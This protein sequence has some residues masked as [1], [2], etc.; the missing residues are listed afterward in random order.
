MKYSKKE[1][2]I[3]SPIKGAG[4]GEENMFVKETNAK[5]HLKV[6]EFWFPKNRV[7]KRKDD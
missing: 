6:P 7:W 4:R 3:K 5:T 2:M 1:Q